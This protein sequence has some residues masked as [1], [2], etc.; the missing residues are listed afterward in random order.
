[1]RTLSSREIEAI[2]GSLGPIGGAVVGG[3]GYL[4]INGMTGQEITI[5]GVAGST[6]A[7]AVTGGFSVLGHGVRGTQALTGAA[8]TANEVHAAGLGALSGAATFGVARH[9]SGGGDGAS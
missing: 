6:V 8:R 5:A 9:L 7:G 4:A 3:L 1:M 2:E